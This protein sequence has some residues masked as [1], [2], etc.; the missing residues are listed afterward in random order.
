MHS[1]FF[2]GAAGCLQA[3]HGPCVKSCTHAAPGPLL[4]NGWR[5]ASSKTQDAAESAQQEHAFLSLARP[6][7]Y[8]VEVK[9][10][11]FVVT[12]WPIESGGKQAL[13]LIKGAS[14]PDATHNCFAYR[15]GQ[16]FRSSD[17][18]EPGGTAGRPIL[19]AIEGEGLQ[20]VA[21]LVTRYFGGTKLG[22][23]GLVRAYGGAARD[24]LRAAPKALV[25]AQACLSMTLTF[26]D[27][28]PVYALI[29][30]FGCERL[31]EDYLEGGMLVQLKVSLDAGAQEEFIAAVSDC[32][33]GK[34]LPAPAQ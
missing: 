30:K 18:G 2:R 20:S 22:A 14:D 6:V 25:K 9:K 10:S 32:T 8:E 7:T 24:C 23:G 17:D 1:V 26:E 3:R 19:S 5:A 15:A 33:S 34:V 12:A 28:G 31:G 21:V 27:M 16:E 11:R 13:E 4:K 29:Q